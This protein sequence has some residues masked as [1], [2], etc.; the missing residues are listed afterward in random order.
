MA[1]AKSGL[2]VV[3]RIIDGGKCVYQD[4]KRLSKGNDHLDSASCTPRL[5]CIQ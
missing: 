3:E 4:S 2:K 1:S 5:R